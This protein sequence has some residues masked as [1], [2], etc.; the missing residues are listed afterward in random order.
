MTL[1][2][3]TEARRQFDPVAKQFGLICV[4]SSEHGLRYEND[5][6]FLK[7]NFDNG[8]SYE[9]DV[10]IGRQ[11]ARY[12]KPAF[13]LAEILRLRSVQNATFVSRLMNS[14]QSR[15]PS[16]LLR[17]VRLVCD[18]ASDFLSGND[19][20]FAQAEKWR[21]K[22]AAEFELASQLKFARSTVDVAWSKRDYKAIV[23]VLEPLEPYLSPAENKRLEY[24]R[25]KIPH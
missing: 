14:D 13:S 8:R 17:L 20:S 3:S 18:H 19:L 11:C 1:L 12:A 4:R 7:V 23:R 2:F 22:E 10:E 6:V 15:L 9:I 24:S 5:K 21:N 16:I 25:K